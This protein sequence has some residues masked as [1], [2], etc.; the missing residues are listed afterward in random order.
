MAEVKQYT[1]THRE[2]AEALIK[3]QNIHEGWWGIYLEFS[4]RGA[5]VGASDDALMPSA[6]VG[7]TT[8]G[9]QRFPK[10]NN[11]ALDASK[12]NPA[13]S[14]KRSRTRKPK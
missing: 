7:V 2:I 6:I 12:V 8:V 11:L 1:F 3:H 5:N 9:I 14:K 10:E 13:P 4:L